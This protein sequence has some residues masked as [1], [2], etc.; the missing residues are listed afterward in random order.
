MSI[1]QTIGH[2]ISILR[3]LLILCVVFLHTVLAPNI[4]KVDLTDFQTVLSCIFQDRLGRFAVPTLTMISAYLLFGANLD[5]APGK[6]YKKKFATLVVPFFFFNV[7]YFAV[8]Y[9]VATVTGIG[10]LQEVVHKNHEQIINALTGYNGMPLNGATHFLRDLFVLVL[11]T[12]VFSFFLRRAPLVGCFLIGLV[13]L[14]NMDGNLIQRNTMAVMFYLGG[15]CAVSKTDVTILDKHA[16]LACVILLLACTLSVFLRIDNRMIYLLSPF[17]VW[18]AASKLVGT[19]LGNWAAKNSKYSF[20]VFLAHAPMLHVLDLLHVNS[21]APKLPLVSSAIE[22]AVVFIVLAAVYDIAA[23]RMPSL[24]NI[25]IGARVKTVVI[26]DRRRQPR[27]DGAPV[28][29][30]EYRTSF[31]SNLSFR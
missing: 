16:A 10:S 26:A 25:M 28:F 8:V 15:W 30:P 21:I 23:K 12:P 18:S 4:L 2:R 27:P 14:T 6:L 9:A 17:L 22:T 29:S 24:F 3:T 20:F 19:A 1:K 5:Q 31:I 11:L 13:F 7:L